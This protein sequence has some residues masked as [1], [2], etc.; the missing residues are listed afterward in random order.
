MLSKKP[1]AFGQQSIYFMALVN[2]ILFLFKKQESL[3]KPPASFLI[4]E[5]RMEIEIPL[6]SLIFQF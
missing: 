4:K 2:K 1:G 6:Y 3:F 5:G